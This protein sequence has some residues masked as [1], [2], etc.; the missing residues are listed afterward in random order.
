MASDKDRSD[1][2]SGWETVIDVGDPWYYFI[3]T[4]EL[5]SNW[6]QPG[7]NASN[8]SIGPSGFGYGDGDDNTEISNT[9]SVFLVKPFSITDFEQ[10]KKIAFHIDYDDGFVA[11]LNGN[12]IARDNIEGSPPPF[13]QGTVTWRE[14]EMINGGDPSLFGLI[15]RNHGSMKGKIY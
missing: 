2:I 15:Q 8:W 10:I 9:I 7:F 11:Y 1:M 12:E 6:N 3:P 5:P 14:A 13:N 4:Q